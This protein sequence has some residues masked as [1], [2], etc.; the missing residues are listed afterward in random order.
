MHRIR[1]LALMTTLAL[2]SLLSATPATAQ[3]GEIV[4]A[5]QPVRLF[6]DG[7]QTRLDVGDTVKVG[8]IVLTGEGAMAQIIFQD[9]TRIVVGSNAQMKLD[10]LIFRSDNTAKKFTVNATRGAFRFLSGK[11][12]S[13]AYTVRTPIAT[14]GVRGTVFDFTIPAQRNTDLLVYE[15]EV[16][17]CRSGRTRCASVPQGCQ[18]IRM[19][20]RRWNQPRNEQERSQIISEL[21]PFAVEQEQLRPAFRT[22]VAACAGGDS[23]RQLRQVRIERGTSRSQSGGSSSAASPTRSDNPAE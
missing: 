11:S 15:G 10:T 20:H 19:D 14:M 6:L 8:D 9:E 4:E 16:Q 3:T 22:N 2:A 5:V 1:V 23:D 21:F 18:T 7:K 13:N 12:P 17:F